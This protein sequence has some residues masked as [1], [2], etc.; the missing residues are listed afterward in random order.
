M[1][2]AVSHFRT[3]IFL[4]TLF[5][6][7]TL[8]STLVAQEHSNWFEQMYETQSAAQERV[9]VLVAQGATNI[10][11]EKKQTLVLFTQLRIGPISQMDEA[12]R[13][14]RRLA[15]HGVETQIFGNQHIQQLWISVGI[16]KSRDYLQRTKNRVESLGY[17]V[18]SHPFEQQQLRYIVRGYLAED[19]TEQRQ[20][21][22]DSV[23]EKTTEV[24]SALFASIELKNELYSELGRSTAEHETYPNYLRIGSELNWA[25][26][27]GWKIRIGARADAYVL[28][29]VN[30]VRDY[31]LL[32][33]QAYLRYR[34]ESARLTLGAQ[35]VIWGQADEFSP[36][37]LLSRQDIRRGFIDELPERRLATPA[38]RLEWFLGSAK[39]D[40]LYIPN[41]LSP[42]TAD[43]DQFWTLMSP[44]SGQLLG[45]SETPLIARLVTQGSLSIREEEQES[46]GIRFTQSLNSMDWGMSY[47]ETQNPQ[48]YFIV[49]PEMLQ[50]LVLSNNDVDTALAATSGPT[51]FEVHPKIVATGLE[52]AWD[53]G[54]SLL[55]FE[56][57]NLQDMPVTGVDLALLE[58]EQLHWILD[59]EFYPGDKDTRINI[60]LTGN[61]KTADEP[62]LDDDETYALNGQ[63]EYAFAN[64]RVRFQLRSRIGLS[65]ED[66]YLSPKLV[67]R[68]F[69]PHELIVAYHTFDG[70]EQTIGGFFDSRDY[71]ALGWSVAF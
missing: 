38:L 61:R 42:L 36:L 63:L 18:D 50:N 39:L 71:L 55:R 2:I 6:I 13:V 20:E 24:T 66:Y 53:L 65:E 9:D 67:F 26:S 57:A 12:Q 37:D 31:K 45:F 11:I 15:Q 35:T 7:N 62:F 47:L 27:P 41:S 70:D 5:V 10:S 69:E 59:M 29:A 58:S 33:D 43:R 25:L 68:N 16:F 21:V 60:Q 32:L 34:G 44:Q 19:G 23:P 51:F 54:L 56:V 52:F 3:L 17:K 46:G 4:V 28:S 48:P 1:L 14:Q 40:V 22:L 49:S 8:L 30:E 64:D